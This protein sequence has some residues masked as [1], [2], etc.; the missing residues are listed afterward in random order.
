[1]QKYINFLSPTQLCQD[2]SR[3]FPPLGAT[4]IRCSVVSLASISFCFKTKARLSKINS[5][6]CPSRKSFKFNY[7]VYF[8]F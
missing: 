2:Y 5:L 1:M 7:S 6:L 4:P 8:L 3:Q